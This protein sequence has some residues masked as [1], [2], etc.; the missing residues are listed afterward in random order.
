M[1]TERTYLTWLRSFY[2]FVGG[3]SPDNLSSSDVKDFLTHL[4]EERRISP[5]TQNQAFNTVLF[6]YRHVLEK[7]ID[8]FEGALRAKRK[9]RLPVVLTKQEVYAI[10]KHMKGFC[11]LA[12]RL[13]YGGGLRL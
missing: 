8:D 3:K 7:E 2:R 11:L 6:F 12:A 13:I 10:F 4:A 5:S 9:K 1:S